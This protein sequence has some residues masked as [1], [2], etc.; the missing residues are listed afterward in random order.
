MEGVE[1]V[2]TGSVRARSRIDSD[3]FCPRVV[4]LTKW[5]RQRGARTRQNDEAIDELRGRS[6]YK[7]TLTRS[8]INPKNAPHVE[9]KR[10]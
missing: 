9:K 8:K 5:G 2:T 4:K 10:R 7:I 1:E 3:R 6:L